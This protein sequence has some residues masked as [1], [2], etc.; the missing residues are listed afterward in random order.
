MLV[1]PDAATLRGWQTSSAGRRKRW[2]NHHLVPLSI[3]RRPQLAR[4][5]RALGRP[6]P[7]V[8]HLGANSLWLPGDE[9]LAAE[10]G[11][12]LH[13]GPH[14]HYND[15]VAARLERIR[16]AK[17]NSADTLLSIARLQRALTRVLSG[18]TKPILLLHRNDPMRLFAD[19]AVLD[20]AIDTL[21]G[22]PPI[23]D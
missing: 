19:Y 6:G 11:M 5:L 23:A 12:C 7:A 4:F 15:V 18:R 22:M 9:A 1:L 21:I 13:R 20:T 16:A 8:Q 14:P 3:S 2:Q 17:L 10:V